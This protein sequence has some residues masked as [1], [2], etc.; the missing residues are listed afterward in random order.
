M[1]SSSGSP[2]GP[3]LTRGVAADELQEGMPLVGHVGDQAVMIVRSQGTLHAVGATCSH[4]GGP[5]AEGVIAG[6]AV[7]C[8]WHHAAFQLETGEVIRPPALA[9]IPCYP[10][11]VRDGMAYVRPADAAAVAPRRPARRGSPHPESIVVVGGGAAGFSAVRT[12]RSDGYEGRIALVTA[13]ST[14]PVD[15][16]NLS[17]DYLAGNAPEDWIPLRPDAWYADNGIELR[18]SAPVGAI[19]ARDKSVLLHDGTSLRYGALILAPGADPIRLPLGDAPVLY[20]RTLADSRAIVQRAQAVRSAVVIGASFIGLE[21]AASLRTRGLDVTVVAPEEMP[22]ERVLGR[23]L[24]VTVRDVHESH[25]VRFRLGRTVTGATHDAVQLDDGTTIPATLIV[26][27]VGVRP[28][29]QLAEAAGLD[30]N[31][32]IIV[33]ACLRTSAPDIFAAGDA[34]RFPSPHGGDSLRI[35]HWVVAECHGQA[36]ARN[37]MGANEPFVDVP[38]FWSAHYDMTISY[39]GHATRPDRVELD[40]D[41]ARRDC[42]VRY[43]EQDQLRAVATIGRDR[44]SLEA[45]EMLASVPA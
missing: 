18:T 1:T 9:P 21:V 20:L 26:A 12:L 33:D 19:S 34:A 10:V 14:A 44:V 2:E 32:G 35:E 5:L 43:F 42:T 28:N 41:P 31:R 23:D 38:F 16:P 37:A 6:N 13:E 25:G 8:P 45:E 36:A 22:L 4:Y 24:A 11:E 17:K 27:G 40:G 30:V 7:R 15:R 39:V 3:D 29:T